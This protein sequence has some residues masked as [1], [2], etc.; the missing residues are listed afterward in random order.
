MK[1]Y[2]IDLNE[3]TRNRARTIKFLAF[4]AGVCLLL[5]IA[6]FLIF[7]KYKSSKEWPLLLLTVYLA[8]YVYFAWITLKA[9]IYIKAD[10]NEIVFKF[11]IRNRS[12]DYILWETVNRIK[13]GPTYIIFFKRSGR[14]KKFLLSWMPYK[15]V[16]EVKETVVEL[17]ESKNIP[18][19][20]VE[21]ER[22][23]EKKDDKGE[24]E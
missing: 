20:I 10:S 4:G 23:V 13:I 21:F 14:R 2:Y 16:I 5:I 18:C 12:K 17:S 15:K 24:K 1:T 22:F 6:S 11:G 7:F 3:I 9:K 8:L 19:E